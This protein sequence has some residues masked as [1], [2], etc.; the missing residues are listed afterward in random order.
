MQFYYV[1]GIVLVLYIQSMKQE[2][3]CPQVT[4]GKTEA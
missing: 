1:P 3:T 4:D 2:Y